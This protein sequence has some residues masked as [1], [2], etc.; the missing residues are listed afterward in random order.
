MLKTYRIIPVVFILFLFGFTLITVSPVIAED[1]AAF[2]ECQ[3]IKPRGKFRPMK[4]KKNCFRNLAR[5]LQDQSGDSVQAVVPVETSGS[6]VAELNVTIAALQSQVATLSGQHV[7]LQSQV[8]T[9]TT[10]N[11]QLQEP[12]NA[13]IAELETRLSVANAAQEPLNAKMA[14]LETQLS[15]ANAAQE[16]LNAK[17]AELETQ[18]SVANAAQEPLNAKIAGLNAEIATLSGQQ[19]APTSGSEGGMIKI[20]NWNYW[21]QSELIDVYEKVTRASGGGEEPGMCERF[22][23]DTLKPVV[24]R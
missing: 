7:E 4:Q 20:G 15:V 12:L 5:A 22:L 10:T 6:E 14:E 23:M 11:A 24:C 13:K 9:L 3:Q 16:P 19:G 8:A 18:L 1:S 21:R 2:V 17:M